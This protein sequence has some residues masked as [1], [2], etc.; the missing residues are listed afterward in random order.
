MTN[1]R[2]MCDLQVPY[3][4]KDQAKKLGARFNAETKKWYVPHGYD[5]WKFTKW[6]P[7]SLKTQMQLIGQMD[8]QF[9]TR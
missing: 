5:I 6:W 4:E 3:K 9:L 1:S 2:S 8:R 7:E